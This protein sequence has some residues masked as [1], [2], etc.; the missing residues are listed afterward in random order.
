MVLNNF[1]YIDRF[2][3]FFEKICER[4]RGVCVKINGLEKFKEKINDIGK[5]IFQRVIIY[6]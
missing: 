4:E 5:I 1:M 6:V 2:K 3:Q